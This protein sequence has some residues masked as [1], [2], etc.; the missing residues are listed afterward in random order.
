MT[1]IQIFLKIIEK[2][3][4]IIVILCSIL[5]LIN[6]PTYLFFYTIGTI[7]NIILNLTLKYII[8]DNRPS[9]SEK[10]KKIITLANKNDYF[11]SID[12][13]GMPSGHA[14]S[15][16][17]S[18]G[19]M[20]IFIKKSYLLWIYIIISCIT[21]IQRYINNKHTILQLLIGYVIGMIIGLIFYKIGNHSN[22][23]YLFKKKDD[24]AF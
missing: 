3:G 23:G 4:P 9:V 1:I 15:L 21:L 5:Y 8:K 19:F 2:Y 24:N 20:Y 17:F 7:I 14:Q 13:Y 11:N 6:K 16:G 10:E 22:K 12:K 18:I